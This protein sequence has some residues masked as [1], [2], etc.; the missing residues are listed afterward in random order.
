MRGIRA[1]I[2][3]SQLFASAPM[4][5]CGKEAST[6]VLISH[7]ATERPAIRAASSRLTGWRSARLI[8][9]SPKKVQSFSAAQPKEVRVLAAA[10]RIAVSGPAST[11]TNTPE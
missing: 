5:T 9:A 8:S 4:L 10:V 7:S 3:G 11:G 1:S 6:R 2:W